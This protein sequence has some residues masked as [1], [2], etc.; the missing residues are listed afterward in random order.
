MNKSKYVELE[1]YKDEKKGKNSSVGYLVQKTI[2][3][4]QLSSFEGVLKH[5]CTLWTVNSYVITGT[6]A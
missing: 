4:F 3:A 5:T 1:V 6:T 2:K